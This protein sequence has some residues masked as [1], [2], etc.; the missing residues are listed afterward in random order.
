M[1]QSTIRIH[2]LFHCVAILGY[3]QVSSRH[4]PESR[5]CTLTFFTEANFGGA[6]L[7]LSDS[8]GIFELDE[9]SAKTAGRRCWRIYRYLL[10]C[11]ANNGYIIFLHNCLII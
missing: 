3:Y 4:I 8:Q 7:I 2:I 6:E 9:R 1:F 11:T 5:Q 10:N